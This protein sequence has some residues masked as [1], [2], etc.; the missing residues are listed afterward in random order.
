MKHNK[1]RNT[2]FVYEILA[3]EFTKAV[4]DCNVDRKNKLVAI[5]K[6]H[7][8]CSSI[9]A[10][11]LELYTALLETR[12]VDRAVAERL[13]QETKKAYERLDEKTIFGAQS[14]LISVLNKE[15]GQD[16][17]K[18]F[19]PNFKSLASI[20]A[21]FN[22]GTSVK[23]RVLF[24][25]DI[26]D[27]M[28]SE[29]S[30]LGSAQMKPLD[31]LTY[32]SFIKKFNDKYDGLLGEQKELLNHYI[33]SFADGGFSMNV[34]LNSELG[35]LKTIMSETAQEE[36]ESVVGGKARGVLGYLDELRTR[37]FTENDLTKVLKTQELVKELKSL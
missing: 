8:G 12:N 15:V 30:L 25:Q 3:R 5:I 33:A 17:W 32:N 14:K 37:V 23:K 34:Y 16:V 28:S 27:R 18:N 2:A 21:V 6:E 9:L 20:N 10:Q 19:V 13:L 31:S 35:R 26:V 7:F 36:G 11:E 29:S 22:T 24:E 1:K 4:I